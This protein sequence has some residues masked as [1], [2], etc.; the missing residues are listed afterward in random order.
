VTKEN[1]IEL[2]E[3]LVNTSIEQSTA[4]RKRTRKTLETLISAYKEIL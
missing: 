3:T 4:Y 2:I 1:I